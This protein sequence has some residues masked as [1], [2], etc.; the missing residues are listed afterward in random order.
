MSDFV[1]V[2]AVASA[3]TPRRSALQAFNIRQVC[4]EQCIQEVTVEE[5]EPMKV[6]D[7]VCQDR[8]LVVLTTTS[9]VHVFSIASSCTTATTHSTLVDFNDSHT[10]L[11]P[12]QSARRIPLP[13][14]AS[15]PIRVVPLVEAGE[16]DAPR[17]REDSLEA[18]GCEKDEEE[19]EEES[20][21]LRRLL[22]LNHD[23]TVDLVSGDGAE[24]KQLSDD[25]LC[26]F[27]VK[28]SVATPAPLRT[29]VLL[30]GQHRYNV[31]VAPSRHS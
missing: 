11:L 20:E 9:T 12:L 21:E 14:S 1:F 2:I 16:P 23:H 18:F 5:A 17:S 22:L 7:V 8:C 29:S 15:V 13:P 3:S 10:V 28:G 4:T 26:L 30:F 27:L 25:A 19:E 24:R 31:R 6:C